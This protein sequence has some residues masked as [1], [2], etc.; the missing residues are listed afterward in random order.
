MAD[1]MGEGINTPQR[2]LLVAFQYQVLM[3][4][5]VVFLAQESGVNLVRFIVQSVDNLIRNILLDASALV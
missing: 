2:R 1:I 3:G 5:Q 4:L